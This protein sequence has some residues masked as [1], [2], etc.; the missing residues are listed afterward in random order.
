MVK[1]MV[2]GKIV[3]LA[4]CSHA[5]NA[6]L[7]GQSSSVYSLTVKRTQ[8]WAPNILQ[9]EPFLVLEEFWPPSTHV[10]NLMDY[11]VCLWRPWGNAQQSCTQ[12][13]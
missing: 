12:H 7:V 11:F 3:Q 5:Q 1:V 4:Y 13:Q 8:K 6:Y 10:L 9:I 2:L